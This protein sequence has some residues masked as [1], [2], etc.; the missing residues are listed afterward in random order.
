MEDV[1]ENGDE[2][3]SG[4]SPDETSEEQAPVEDPAVVSQIKLNKPV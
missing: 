4:E 2:A 3:A 1:V